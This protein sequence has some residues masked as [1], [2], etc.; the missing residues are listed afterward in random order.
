MTKIEEVQKDI[1]RLEQLKEETYK[2]CT[3]LG[4]GPY[5][6]ALERDEHSSLY[7]EI[8]HRTYKL[9]DELEALL[10]KDACNRL[11]KLLDNKNN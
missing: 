1:K 8:V 3:K 9:E 6:Y 10:R 7:N 11:D 5:S 2:K 4:C